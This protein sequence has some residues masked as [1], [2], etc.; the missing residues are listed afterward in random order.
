MKIPFIVGLV[1]ADKHLYRRDIEGTRLETLCDHAAHISNKFQW[2]VCDGDNYLSC[3]NAPWPR[4]VK[5]EC[6]EGK[7]CKDTTNP[8]TPLAKSAGCV[9]KADA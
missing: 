5:I 8:D 3:G 9:W 7:T 4:V 6:G 1:L 2:R